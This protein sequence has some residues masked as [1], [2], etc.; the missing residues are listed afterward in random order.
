MAIR[1]VSLGSRQYDQGEQFT[2]AIPKQQSDGRLITAEMVFGAEGWGS[3]PVT[4]PIINIIREVSPDGTVWTENG[5]FN[6]HRRAVGGP[7]T[8]KT[9]WG[10]NRQPERVR[11]RAEI[12]VTN[13]TSVLARTNDGRS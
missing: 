12:L 7:T 3:I 11:F 4:T 6:V 13:T 1:E 5:R 10:G 2:M 8:I 9:S